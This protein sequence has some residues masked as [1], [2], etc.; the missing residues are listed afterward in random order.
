MRSFCFHSFLTALLVLSTT[1]VRRA[2]AQY[3]GQNRVQ[4]ENFKFEILQ[5]DHFDVYF[6]PEEREAAQQAARMAERWYARHRFI[7]QHELS[8]R[9]PIL[10]YASHPHFEQT[11]ALG[12]GD[13]GEGTGGVTEALLRRIV[14]PFAGPIAETDHVIGHELVH[15]FQYDIT[16]VNTGGRFRSEAGLQLPLWF[17]EGMAEFLSLGPNDPNTAMWMRDAVKSQKKLPSVRQLEDSRYFPYRYGQALLA[18]IAGRWGDDKI[19]DLLKQA[20]KS[21]DLERAIRQVL[22][23]GPDTLA[24]DWHKAL[25]QAYDPLIKT[26]ESPD[27]YGKQIIS[28][29][30]GGSEL[31]VGP[32][33]SPDG[34][35]VIFFS[36]K[37]LF[38][39][40]LFLADAETGKIKRNILRAERNPHLES[41]EFISSAGAWDASGDRIAFA[42]V[43]K[44][45][46]GIG[47]LNVKKDKIAR[48]IRLP[49]LGEV[50]NPT[51]SP[52]GRQI[53]FS[54]LA[55]GM[56]DIFI[57]DL[58]T[59][60]LRRVTND[61]HS[62]LHP[63][64][65]P[66]GKQIV[67]A[68]D[69]FTADLNLLRAGNY[70]LALYDVATGN[71][72]QVPGFSGGKHLN[73]QWS[74]DGN[75]IYFISDQDGISNIY[76]VAMASGSLFRVTNL[77]TGVSGITPSS[78]ALSVAQKT[79]RLAFS[80]F[81]D[82]KYNIY[83]VDAPEVLAGKPAAQSADD[84]N[85][86]ELPPMARVVTKLDSVLHNATM[87]LSDTSTERVVNYSSKLRLA[88][89]GQPTL[90]AGYD[91]YGAF[92]GGGLSFLWSDM[93]GNHT[94]GLVTQ[95]QIDGAFRDFAGQLGYTN[96]THRLNWGVVLQQIPYLISQSGE[97]YAPGNNGDVLDVQEELRFRQLNQEIAGLLA[98]PL[99]R[100]Q[101][102]EFSAGMQ[103]ISF[104]EQLRTQGFSLYTGQKAI[105]NTQNLPTPSA[106]Y[107]ADADLA[108]VY[109]SSVFGATS[110][111]IGQ[112]YRI[113]FSPTIGTIAMNTLLADYRRYL[114]PIKPITVAGRLLHLGRY[115]KNAED[116]RLTPLFLGYPGLVRGYGSNSF[117]TNEFVADS[118]TTFDSPVFDRLIGS[119]L[120]IANFEVRFPLLGLLHLGPG[121]YGVFPIETGVFYDA[122]WA[123][124]R[125]DKASFLGGGRDAVRSY[126][127]TARLNL[128]GYAVVEAD[129]VNPVDR[130]QK[131][132]FWQ[133]NFT[134]GF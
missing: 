53:A 65:S 50:F 12:G 70:R 130:P 23:V 132:W 127:A 39:I 106:L 17:I 110:P 129:Y 9:Q 91:S 68:T 26:T 105:D 13:I 115:G 20:G 131:G 77:Y 3:F 108:L 88:Y 84:A 63:A 42:L 41:L 87:G 34:K 67:F 58:Q 18:Y 118:D 40:D 102:V 49:Q 104:S 25:H 55:N 82:G 120:A 123:W 14:V 78:P 93:L 6:Y 37:G 83:T 33:L 21:G 36:E 117:N 69:R 27:K 47:I 56:S 85:P 45:R 22:H 97:F 31:N 30:R 2:E 112:S 126:G 134:A 109:D 43:T 35:N 51:W 52:D 86:A 100:T 103:R 101:R 94:L 11:N 124:T 80:V 60:S 107:L 122:G 71:I 74:P 99:S 38:A 24:S 4:Y 62:D 29:K 59:D 92:L 119:R 81:E 48:E 57:Y 19:G 64:W 32:V 76:R 121:F 75:S 16:G 125:K 5:T 61:F 72:S 8:G 116:G 113:D 95:A 15:A 10:L 73:P 7:L 111:L 114:M 28:K 44:G 54:A 89:I 79:N 90:A 1:L 46:P 66:D 133:F 96:T 128:L 98:Y